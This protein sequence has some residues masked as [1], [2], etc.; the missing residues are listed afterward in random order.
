[1][2]VGAAV[3]RVLKR[4][5]WRAALVA[6]SSWSHAFLTPKNYFMH[7]DI[8]ADRNVYEM[9]A[10]SDYE[11]LRKYKLEDIENSGQQEVLNWFCLAGAM[12]ELGR[13]PD[14]TEFL[15]SWIFNSNKA[16]AIYS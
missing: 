7:P 2:E 13:K 12:E 11:A 16:F 6:S 3:A 5:P 9:L 15:E 4:S 8:P 10:A 14:Y 1:M